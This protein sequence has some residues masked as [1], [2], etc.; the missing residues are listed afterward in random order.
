M[1]YRLFVL[2][3]ICLFF[4]R[5]FFSHVKWMGIYLVFLVFRYFHFHPI[6]MVKFMEINRAF[7]SKSQI[8]NKI[9]FGLAAFLL[10]CSAHKLCQF[11]IIAQI[12]FLFSHRNDSFISIF[13]I[14][15][16]TYKLLYHHWKSQNYLKLI[17]KQYFAQ[18]ENIQLRQRKKKLIQ[19]ILKIN[20]GNIAL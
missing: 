5:E 15:Y 9:I 10:Q 3:I 11:E 17:H 7:Y 8:K 12:D 4:S 13:K 19:Q 14:P 16:K 20:I 6:L 2:I 18:N 1:S